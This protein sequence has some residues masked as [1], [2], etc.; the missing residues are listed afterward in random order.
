MNISYAIT[1]HNEH[2]EIDRLLSI[3]SEYTQ[4][5]DEIV[6]LRDENTTEE[7]VSILEKY[8]DIVECEYS[9][10]NV[11]ALNRD[12]AS[13][14]NHLSL[15]CRNEYQFQIDADEYPSTELVILLP[16]IL[17]MNAGIDLIFI[18]RVNTVDG[19]TQ[20]H[21]DRWGW[22]V[23]ES[24]WVNWP[25]WQWRIFR[26]T[27]E[28][29]WINR[30]HERLVGYETYTHLPEDETYCLYHPK[31]IERQVKQNEL[32]SEITGG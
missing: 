2:N 23:N 20:Q 11:H 28:I 22:R 4:E 31:D 3:L 15:L 18:P 14:K 8:E 19:L 26:N 24:G 17:E 6:V 21:I 16:E 32:Y 27:L 10:N 13:H 12:F 29:Y 5:E 7:V 25:D 30:V 1:V 9:H